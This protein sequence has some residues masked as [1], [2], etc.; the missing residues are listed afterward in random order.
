LL[1]FSIHKVIL[2][3]LG[4]PFFPGHDVY[5]F[6][7]AFI[8]ITLENMRTLYLVFT[9]SRITSTFGKSATVYSYST[10]AYVL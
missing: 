9:E 4:G 8:F 7:Q 1:T 6:L 2:T 10:I 3:C 5:T